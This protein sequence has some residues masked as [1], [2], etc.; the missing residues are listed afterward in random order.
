MGGTFNDWDL[1][2]AGWQSFWEVARPQKWQSRGTPKEAVPWPQQACLYP[3]GAQKQQSHR[4]LKELCELGTE[5][6]R[7]AQYRPTLQEP[8]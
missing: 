8:L 7:A 3:Y 5:S 1:C 6:F 2:P 4:N